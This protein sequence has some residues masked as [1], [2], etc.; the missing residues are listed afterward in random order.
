[1]YRVQVV[2]DED[3]A[4]ALVKLA[5]IKIRDPRDQIRVLVRGELERQGLLSAR[6]VAAAS[7]PSD[8]A[9]VSRPVHN[10]AGNG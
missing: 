10:G 9:G 3:E 2:L 8:G 1:M 5:E 4:K 6:E 7:Q